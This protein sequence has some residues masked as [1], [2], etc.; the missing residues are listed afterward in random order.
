MWDGGVGAAGD[1]YHISITK[2]LE[3]LLTWLLHLHG[4][5]DL[6]LWRLPGIVLFYPLQHLHLL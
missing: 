3:Q 6:A 4:H 1:T 2:Q 5:L